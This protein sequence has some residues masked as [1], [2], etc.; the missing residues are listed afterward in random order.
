MTVIYGVVKQNMIQLPPGV[1]LADGEQVEIRVQQSEQDSQPEKDAE[2]RFKEQLLKLGVFSRI[3]KPAS[4][5]R[6]RLKPIV[7]P[8]Q[9]L[10][11]QIIA[12]R[13]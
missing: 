9:P 1:E 6:R 10:S 5:V 12:D 4:Y 8:G 11:E 7:I 13:R 2:M 3:A